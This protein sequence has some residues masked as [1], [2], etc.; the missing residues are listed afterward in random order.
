MAD[1]AAIAITQR[2]WIKFATGITQGVIRRPQW[3]NAGAFKY[4]WTSRDTTGVAPDN[5]DETDG[6]LSMVLFEKSNEEQ[7][8]SVSPQDFYVYAKKTDP[9][10]TDTTSLR[11]DI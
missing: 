1:P 4:F 9:E 7:I 10:N 2:V 11:L 6:G 8:E 5:E 3:N